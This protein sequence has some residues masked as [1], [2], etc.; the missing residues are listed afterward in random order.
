MSM[1]FYLKWYKQ[2]RSENVPIH[3]PLL[4]IIFVNPETL[5]VSY[6]TF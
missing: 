2:G 6:C 4:I 3:G 5:I 1:R